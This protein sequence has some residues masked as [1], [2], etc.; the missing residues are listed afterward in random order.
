MVSLQIRKSWGNSS[1]K[2]LSPH[3][4]SCQKPVCCPS[5]TTTCM[6][7]IY[8]CFSLIKSTL[9]GES[10]T[11]P[12]TW[13]IPCCMLYFFLT[14]SCHI[15]SLFSRFHHH[16]HNKLILNISKLC[17]PRPAF[18]L[19]STNNMS[20]HHIIFS[21]LSITLSKELSDNFI[22]ILPILV[23][24]NLYIEKW[25]ACMLVEHVWS[26]LLYHQGIAFHI[27]AIQSLIHYFFSWYPINYMH[28]TSTSWHLWI[29][30]GSWRAQP[31]SH[32]SHR[33][34]TVTPS[35]P[36]SSEKYFS[37]QTIVQRDI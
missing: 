3:Y 5:P 34:V 16:L 22:F 6:P 4:K 25:Y 2:G 18:F 29:P 23:L 12:L 19:R 27:P 33:H 20:S 7:F 36:H 37:D 17:M 26:W 8:K 21:L 32:R 10:F 14:I 24:E 11:D 13:H 31:I 35:R 28:S 15:P 9:H 30:N 1:F